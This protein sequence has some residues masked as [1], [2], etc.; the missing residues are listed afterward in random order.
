MLARPSRSQLV[1]TYDFVVKAWPTSGP[2]PRPA[3]CSRNSTP[4]PVADVVDF[5]LYDS[6]AQPDSDHENR[7]PG[8]NPWHAGVFG[9]HLELS[10]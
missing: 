9:L 3:S 8:S 7:V 5:D 4:P 6:F 1:M 2:F 10:P